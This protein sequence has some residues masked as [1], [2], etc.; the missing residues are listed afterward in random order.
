MGIDLIE[1][2]PMMF[3]RLTFWSEL[4]ISSHLRLK[5]APLP[6][7][8][9]DALDQSTRIFTRS[10]TA[11]TRS[12]LVPEIAFGRLNRGVPEQQLNLLEFP[13]GLAAELG[14]GSPQIVGRQ[15]RMPDGGAG[16]S[17]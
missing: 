17:Y 14:A 6:T 16:P 4:A 3:C 10:L 9:L 8:F 13:S 2:T 7:F 12:C 1:T 15:I 11:W 5:Q